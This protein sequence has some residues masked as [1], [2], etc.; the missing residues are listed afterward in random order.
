MEEKKFDRAELI[1][2]LKRLET[3]TKIK[4]KENEI[5]DY[6]SYFGRVLSF[7]DK[8]KA[9]DEK[10]NL[11]RIDPLYHVWEKTSILRV[12][13][14]YIPKDKANNYLST[15]LPKGYL[16]KNGFLRIPWKKR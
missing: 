6:I 10:V 5:K 14:T 2:E 9:I 8:I 1:D 3:I 7:F 16:D 13:Q 4:I 12:P 15:F 11:N